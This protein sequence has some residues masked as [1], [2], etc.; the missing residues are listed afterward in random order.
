MPR[1]KHTAVQYFA[2]KLGVPGEGL[3]LVYAEA[4]DDETKALNL[5]ATHQLDTDIG[6]AFFN[7]PD[8]MMRDLLGD[9]ASIDLDSRGVGPLDADD[10]P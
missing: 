7:D 1:A 8:R 3:R 6:V 4:I 2:R 9:A 5:L 10:R